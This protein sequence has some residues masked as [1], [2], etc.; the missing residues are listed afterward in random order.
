[1]SEE[2]FDP[3]DGSDPF[4]DVDEA[5][6]DGPPFIGIPKAWQKRPCKAKC[7]STW[8]V[9]TCLLDMRYQKKRLNVSNCMMEELG[10][11]A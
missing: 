3:D 9:A 1:V 11:R 5:K 10:F 7:V 8:I 6:G 4:A 2:L